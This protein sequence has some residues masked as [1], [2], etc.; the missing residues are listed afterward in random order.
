M[1]R[2]SAFSVNAKAIGFCF[3]N[4]NDV[5]QDI[6]CQTEPPPRANF[7]ATANQVRK[8]FPL[9]VNDF[10]QLFCAT[11]AVNQQYVYIIVNTDL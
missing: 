10:E 11:P 4:Q 6:S 1:L 2:V 9:L 8:Y 7:S 5:L 3:F